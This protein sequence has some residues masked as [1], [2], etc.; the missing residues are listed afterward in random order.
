M[1]GG[2][3]I[4]NEFVKKGD[5]TGFYSAKKVLTNPQVEVGV[6][7]TARGGILRKGLGFKNSKV[8]IITSLA[9]DHIGI[10]WYKRY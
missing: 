6:L 10:E 1:T 9:E 3:I 8:A 4:N 2:I 7:E 5:T